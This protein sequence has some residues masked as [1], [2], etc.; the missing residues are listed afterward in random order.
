MSDDTCDDDKW[1]ETYNKEVKK[2]K[3]R[4]SV[5]ASDKYYRPGNY[6][7]REQGLCYQLG[8]SP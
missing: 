3:F 4:G 7:Y 1:R 8:N 2:I 5:K 6:N